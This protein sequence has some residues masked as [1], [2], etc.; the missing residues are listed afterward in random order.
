[1]KKL[2]M[3]AAAMFLIL[4]TACGSVGSSSKN[5]GNGNNNNSSSVNISIITT[6]NMR[7]G[8]TLVLIE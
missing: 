7:V 6:P 1:M 4:F 3:V 5:S 2:V 8:E